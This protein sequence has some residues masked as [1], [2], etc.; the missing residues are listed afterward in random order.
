VVLP[1][2]QTLVDA[3]AGEVS[4]LCRAMAGPDDGPDCAQNTWVNALR[5]YPS[6]RSATNLRGWLLTIA[7]RT[8]IDHH[9]ARSRRAIPVEAVPEQPTTSPHLPDDDLWVLVRTLPERQRHAVA[10]RYVLD[11]PHAD[12]AR[13]LGVSEAMSRRLVSDA[14]ATL[15]TQWST[16]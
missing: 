10:L 1:P 13:S 6:L 11:L 16:S 5:A 3:Y 4:R 9:R 12:V 7:A 2:F 14:L 8:A 15:R